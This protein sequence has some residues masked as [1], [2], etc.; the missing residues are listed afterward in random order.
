VYGAHRDV[1][2]PKLEPRIEI[3][4]KKL[5]DMY[6]REGSMSESKS[7]IDTLRGRLPDDT[8]EKCLKNK[9][10]AGIIEA[11]EEFPELDLVFPWRVP[12]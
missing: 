6:L 9:E 10:V 1:A 2:I 11:R 7:Y 4:A 3:Y 5:R 12:F 8:I